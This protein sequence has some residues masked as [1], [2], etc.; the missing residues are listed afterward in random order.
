MVTQAISLHLQ[1]RVRICGELLQSHVGL[2][3][4]LALTDG[5]QAVRVKL[6]GSINVAITESESKANADRSRT[7][8]SDTQRRHI[9]V[10]RADAAPAS[11]SSPSSFFYRSISLLGSTARCPAMPSKWSPTVLESLNAIDE[12]LKN[13][14]SMETVLLL[15]ETGY[16]PGSAT[17]LMEADPP[18][19]IPSNSRKDNGIWR[20][21]FRMQST[22]FLSVLFTSSSWDYAVR[23]YIPFP[24]INNNIESLSPVWVVPGFACPPP[25][26]FSPH[27]FDLQNIDRSLP[28]K[29]GS[30]VL[31]R[32][33]RMK[34]NKYFSVNS[35]KEE[36]LLLKKLEVLSARAKARLA[37]EEE[38]ER[39][40]G[41]DHRHRPPKPSP[42]H[43]E[44]AARPLDSHISSLWDE[45]VNKEDQLKLAV[46]GIKSLEQLQEAYQEADADLNRP[47]YPSVQRLKPRLRLAWEL[48]QSIPQKLAMKR[49]KPGD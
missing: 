38:A 18:E 11:S 15:G 29:H 42:P 17:H 46:H 2:N 35:E 47:P 23:L 24:G 27:F 9:G 16:S 36:D 33:I 10:L 7:S 49:R 5:V 37:K 21:T 28:S 4:P 8:T 34:S 41:T 40:A 20:R 32:R 19:W 25:E 44:T 14:H 31:V 13:A 26:P 30:L 45:V 39:K 22:M 3:V 48:Y 6:R 12:S 43:S 1:D